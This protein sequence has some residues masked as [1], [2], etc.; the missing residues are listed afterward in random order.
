[1][2]RAGPV[3]APR[4]APLQYMAPEQIR[5]AKNVDARADV[6]SLGAVLYEL[7]TGVR[8]FSGSD[9]LDVLNRVAGGVYTPLLELVSRIESVSAVRG[10]AGGNA[11]AGLGGAAAALAVTIAEGSGTRAERRWARFDS[12]GLVPWWG[13]HRQWNLRLRPPAV[14]RP[15][16]VASSH[17]LCHIDHLGN[18]AHEGRL[19]PTAA[20]V[21]QV[22]APRPASEVGES[23]LGLQAVAYRERLAALGDT[24]VGEAPVLED[25]AKDL[26]LV[27]HVNG[28]LILRAAARS[29]GLPS[30]L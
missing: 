8:C 20:V 30:L 17:T 28:H 29:G 24:E 27:L 2:S 26:G 14:G 23:C 13:S 4:W 9:T 15:E 21:A 22:E 11:A 10:V 16:V 7:V 12:T 1:M 25:T 5:D 3:T 19:V 18:V 6:F